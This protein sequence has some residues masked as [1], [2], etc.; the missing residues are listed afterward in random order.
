M[1][2]IKRNKFRLSDIGYRLLSKAAN[3]KAKTNV[4]FTL[5]ELLIASVI[6][7]VIS[8]AIYAGFNNGIEVWRRVN[9][10][11]PAEDLNIFF[12]KF[13]RDLRSSFNFMNINFSGKSTEMEFAVLI[14]SP[15]L[16]KISVGK[17]IYYYDYAKG[18]LNRQQKDYSHIYSNENGITRQVL[19]NIKSL[20]FRYYSYDAQKKEYF[21]QDEFLKEG[22]PVSVRVEL[23]IE[24]D[25]QIYKFQRTVNIAV[26]G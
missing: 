14:N 2:Y 25:S 20:R 18:A 16:Q 4:G 21:W 13:A 11:L 19:K 12:D 23:E 8:F 26:S 15:R 3:R 5:I 22:L 7:S 9:K 6:V 1:R 17:V 10:E 24:E